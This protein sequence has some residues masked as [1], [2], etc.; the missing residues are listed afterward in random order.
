MATFDQWRQKSAM[1]A[2]WPGALLL[3]GKQADGC[4]GDSGRGAE[5]RAAEGTLRDERQRGD[6]RR[7][8]RGDAR[9]ATVPVDDERGRERCEAVH[10]HAEL[11]GGD[12]EM[13][14]W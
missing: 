3:G 7:R 10:G 6:R 8:L 13:T 1:A 14:V 12:E 9:R 4:G 11:D 5:I 2:R